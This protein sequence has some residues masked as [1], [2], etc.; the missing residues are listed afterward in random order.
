MDSQLPGYLFHEDIE[1][2]IRGASQL[3]YAGHPEE[4]EQAEMTS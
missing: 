2:Y 4:D 3:R 1:K